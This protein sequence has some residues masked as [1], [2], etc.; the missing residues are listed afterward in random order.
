MDGNEL[1]NANR[2][3]SNLLYKRSKPCF[4]ERWTQACTASDEPEGPDFVL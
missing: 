4:D 3:S 1:A 2:A